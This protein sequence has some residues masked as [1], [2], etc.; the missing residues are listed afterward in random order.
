MSE[1]TEMEIAGIKFKGGKIFLV[2]TALS[3]LVGGAYGAFEVYKDY[4]DMKEQIQNYVAPDLSGIE[5]QISTVN[6]RVVGMNTNMNETAERVSDIKNDL[7]DDLVRM[8]RIIDQLEDKLQEQDGDVRQMIQNAEERF[9]NKR[10]A[11]QNDYDSAKERLQTQTAQ[12][13]K[14]LEDR[15]NKRLQRAL[16]NPLAN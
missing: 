2:I 16:D 1:Q 8:E 13:L 12:E 9:E 10:D 5:K 4:M 7:R 3:T 15:L 14:D 11:L 6:E